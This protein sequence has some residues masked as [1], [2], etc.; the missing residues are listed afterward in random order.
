MEMNPYTFFTLYRSLK[1][2]YQFVNDVAAGNGLMAK[3]NKY[4]PLF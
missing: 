2:E 4:Q 3:E 1:R